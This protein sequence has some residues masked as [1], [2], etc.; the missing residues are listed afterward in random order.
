[1]YAVKALGSESVFSDFRTAWCPAGKKL[2]KV[3]PF[4]RIHGQVDEILNSDDNE[5]IN[6]LN[7]TIA[8]LHKQFIQERCSDAAFEELTHGPRRGSIVKITKRKAV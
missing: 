1:M 3:L 6:V 8:M 5:W 7:V 2:M 4:G